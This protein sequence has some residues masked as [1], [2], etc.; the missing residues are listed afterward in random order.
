MVPIRIIWLRNPVK[1]SSAPIATAVVGST[2]LRWKNRMLTATR[3]A[4]AG[5]AR[6]TKLI[7]SC[8]TVSRLSGTVVGA[9]PDSATALAKRADIETRKAKTTRARLASLRAS[10]MVSRPMS[11]RLDTSAD[12]ATKSSTPIST[13]PQV[14]RR[15]C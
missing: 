8:N 2:P 1:P 14:R 4:V 12:P 5:M 7:A 15:S 9:R 6:L 3:P 11:V 10:A 13:R